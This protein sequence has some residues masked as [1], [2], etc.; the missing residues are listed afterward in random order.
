M[1]LYLRSCL[2]GRERTKSQYNKKDEDEHVPKNLPKGN[3]KK[4]VNIISL[5]RMRSYV[6][7]NLKVLQLVKGKGKNTE[8]SS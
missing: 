4:K 2:R 6:H 3:G 8:V 5:M 7:K 1:R